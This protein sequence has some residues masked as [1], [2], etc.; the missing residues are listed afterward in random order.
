M[1]AKA[2]LDTGSTVKFEI[3]GSARESVFVILPV[4]LAMANTLRFFSSATRRLLPRAATSRGECAAIKG[5]PGTA[6]RPPSL[7]I[8]KPRITPATGSAV[9]KNSV[10]TAVDIPA[11]VGVGVGEMVGVGL[12]VGVGLPTGVGDTVGVGEICGLLTT[13]LRGEIS[14]A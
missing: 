5:E 11:G 7:L 9:N 13:S 8:R 12:S 3:A 6:E 2:T 1:V 14:Q 10:G 4:W